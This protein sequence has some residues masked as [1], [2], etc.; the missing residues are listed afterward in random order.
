MPAETRWAS[1]E[2]AR[3]VRRG[4]VRKA[5]SS[6]ARRTKWTAA[7]FVTDAAHQQRLVVDLSTVNAFLEDRP[8]KY[9]SLA[10]FVSQLKLGARMVSWNISDAFYQ[11]P[12]A[13][14]ESAWLAF[15]V[16]GFL[17]VP[18]YLPMGLK[19]A[20]WSLTKVLRPVLAHLLS[21]EVSI[22]GYM[23]DFAS[24]AAGSRPGSKAAAT[25]SRRRAVSLFRWL[26]LQMHPSK[27][28]ATGTTSLYLHGFWN[29][30]GSGWI[31]CGTFSSSRPA[32]STRS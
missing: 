16:E 1:G 32:A 29:H 18:L 30:T 7:T 10:S 15:E 9:E 14:S 19:L 13:P 11:I 17:Y 3:W 28:A 12:H 25:S 20:P 23:D 6:K 26:G 8:F 22:L 21:R 5:K 2:I 24:A 4:F 31:P 27:G